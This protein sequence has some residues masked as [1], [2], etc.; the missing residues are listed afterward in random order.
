MK[1]RKMKIEIKKKI[2]NEKD[3]E[4]IEKKREKGR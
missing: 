1:K 2:L 3:E 4:E